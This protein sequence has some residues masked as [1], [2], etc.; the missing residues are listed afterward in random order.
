[1]LRKI[2][3]AGM[4]VCA[5][6]V[7]A[8]TLFTGGT[9]PEDPAV[10]RAVIL[11]FS[12]PA[13]FLGIPASRRLNP[14]VDQIIGLALCAAN[15]A[16]C[17]WIVANYIRIFSNP[18]LLPTDIVFGII[19]IVVVLEAT[20]RTVGMAVVIVLLVAIAFALWGN[21]VPFAIIRHQGMNLNDLTSGIFFSTDGVFGQPIGI[22]AT[23]IAAIVLLSSFLTVTGG[24]ELF[25]EAAKSIAGRY[26]GGPAKIAVLSSALFGIISG[27]TAANA[28]TCGAVTVP[29]MKRAGY[30]PVVAAA[31]EALSSCGGQIMPPVMG[32]AAFLM[33]DYINQ[34]YSDVMRHAV[35]PALLFFFSVFVVV[36]LHAKKNGLKPVPREEIPPIRQVLRTRGHMLLPILLL[37]VMMT[38]RYSIMYSAFAATVCAIAA[39]FLHKS[40]RPSFRTMLEVPT[41]MLRALAPLVAI[42]AGAGILIGVLTSTGLNLKLTYLI[43][44]AGGGNLAL[45]LFLTMIACLILGMG[46]PT[47]A[48]YLVLATLIP[49]SLVHLGIPLVSAHFFIFYFAVLS[50]ITPPVAIAAYVTAGIANSDP[51]KVGI[52]AVRLGFVAFLLPYAFAYSPSLLMIGGWFDV[53]SHVVEAVIGIII[54]GAGVIGYARRPLVIWE[55]LILFVAGI[56]LIWPSH[57]MSLVGVILAAITLG[58]GFAFERKNS[59]RSA[60]QGNS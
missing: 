48:A 38:M 31:I 49:T 5:T 4:I 28:A 20:R 30:P 26:V 44:I 55:R 13:I 14:Q 40:T 2:V 10:Q 17:G 21:Y 46:L 18:F 35:I 12:L 43:D 59:S 47:V 36:H 11:A 33:V 22:A 53:L 45:T 23:L 56:L 60:I 27:S 6:V 52:T 37:I 7:V 1:M 29:L 19:G 58:T 3:S 54:W 39:S 50:A 8:F 42:C 51:V 9:R 25:M 16:V 57:W 24:S 41:D 32:A 15:F 34:P